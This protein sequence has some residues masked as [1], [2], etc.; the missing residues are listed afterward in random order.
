MPAPAAPT[1]LFVD[2]DAANRHALGWVFRNAGYRTLEAATGAEALRLAREKPDLV[3]LDV[4]LP[5]IDGFEVCRRI[6]EHPCTRSVAVLEVSGVFVASEDRSQGLDGGADGYLVKPVDPRELLATV[7]SLLRIH[8]AEEAARKAAQEWRATFDAISDAV[9]LLDPAGL[10]LR[11][12]RAACDLLGQPFAELVGQPYAEAVLRVA[13]GGWR[14]EG[15]DT[16]VSSPSILHPPPATLHPPPATRSEVQLGQR[17]FLAT[18]DPI[19]DEQGERIGS[20]HILADITLRKQME[21]QLRQGQKMEAIGRL[22]GGIAH[23]FNNLLTAILGNASLLAQ[24]LDPAAEEHE[25]VDTLERAAWRAAELTRQLL[26]FSRQ[27][28]LWLRPLNLNETVEEVLTLLRRT[29]DPRIEVQARCT[30]DLWPVRADAGQMSQV[31]MNLCLNARDAMPEGGRL[32]LETANRLITEAEAHGSTDTRPGEFVR[33]SVADTGHGIPTDVL[34]RIFDPFFTTKPAGKGTGLGLAMVFGIVK[35]HQGWIECHSAPHTA[36]ERCVQG[37]R[38]DVYLPRLAEPAPTTSPGP[39][40]APSAPRGEMILVADDNDMLRKLVATFLRQNGFQV[41]LAEDGR[42]A[43]EIFERE[44]ERVRLVV[45]DVMMPRLSGPEAMRELRKLN[46]DV[47]IL[48]ASGYSDVEL[49]EAERTR[50]QGFIAKPYREP[51]LIG[52]VRQALSAAKG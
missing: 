3:V 4:N 32:T 45:L 18:A 23:D 39:P 13:G 20:V 38:F 16:S 10:I 2:D 11:C 5:D 35:Q 7:R 41:L 50:V 51:D 22:A 28:L 46:P 42:Q 17:W 1:I 40:I 26:G 15:E 9:C 21:E 14:V 44:R 33:L 25:L 49:T 36:A 43:V 47:P 27:T 37:T 34:P 29:M 12:N 48:L 19:L 52:A 6:K 30:A 8:A 24:R 31:L